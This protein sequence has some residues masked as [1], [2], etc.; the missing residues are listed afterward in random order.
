MSLVALWEAGS[1]LWQGVG[2]VNGVLA[3]LCGTCIVAT[4]V[5]LRTESRPSPLSRGGIS[6]FY[7]GEAVFGFIV[8][9]VEIVDRASR[10]L[11]AQ[12]LQQLPTALFLP[13]GCWLV[14]SAIASQ[15]SSTAAILAV[16]GLL[17][18]GA[19]LWA[20]GSGASAG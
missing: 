5:W 17:L 3:L 7:F 12:D 6:T 2:T 14:G 13:G 9:P 1:I 20:Y 19:G 10:F 4:W 16:A 11:L 18:C 8:A 15:T